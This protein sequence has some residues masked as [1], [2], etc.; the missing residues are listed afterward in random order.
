MVETLNATNATNSENQSQTAVYD[1]VP[2]NSK[3]IQIGRSVSLSCS[4]QKRKE[5]KTPPTPPKTKKEKVES[6]SPRKK[7]S[8][9]PKGANARDRKATFEKMQEKY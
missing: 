3:T 4:E 8:F 5:P 1:E 9:S 7:P 6:P 2:S